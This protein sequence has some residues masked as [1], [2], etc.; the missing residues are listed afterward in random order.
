MSK[1]IRYL[2]PY[3][4]QLIA[5]FVLVYVQV[6][7]DLKLPDFM[8]KIIDQGIVKSDTAIILQNGMQ[9]LLFALVGAACAVGVGYLAS[10]IGAG[11]SKDVRNAVFAK[12]ESFS[13]SEFDK[14][15][16]AFL[17]TCTTNDIQQLQMILIMLL[18]MVIAAPIMGI[19]GIL[20][21]Q[22]SSMSWIIAVAVSVLVA[23]I[24]VLFSFALPQFKKM[25]KLIDRL[26]LV[27][28]EFLTGLRVIRAFNTQKHEESKFDHVNRELTKVQLFVN[29]LMAM[30]MPFMMLAMNLTMVAI[31]WF[32][33]KRIDAGMLQVGDMMAFIQYAMLIMMSFLM[34]TMVFIILPR[35]S[36]S[37][38]RIRQV[39]ETLPT[40]VDPLDPVNLNGIEVGSI[41]FKNVSF[42]YPGAE[43]PVLRNITFA[44][45]PGETTA[46]IG[47]TGC[48][49]TTLINL[50]PR[51]YDVT[52][53]QVL[54]D[55]IDVRTLRQSELR[56]KIGYVPQKGSLFSGTV[57]S[58]IKFGKLDATQEE[59]EHAAQ[60]AQA[61]G[62]ILEKDEKFEAPIAQGG[63]NVSGGQRQRLAIARALIKKPEVYI[64]DDSF[65]ALDYK[66]DVALRKALQGET[67][68]STVLIVAQR[69]GTI[70]NADRIIVLEK[71]EIAG[72]GTHSELMKNCEVYREIA[73]S[74]LSKEE[75]A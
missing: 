53:G 11:F 18:R 72:I 47:S 59:V 9:M 63:T 36:V 44:A 61:I 16:P 37:A 64:F 40:V 51:F 68:A 74:Q 17:I 43:E 4:L 49:K 42:S 41:E 23:V 29:R 25:Q 71:G 69:I 39:L 21:I 13:L 10:R 5:L 31:I 60:T 52:G 73:F 75:L 12:V 22:H 30:L 1:L 45:Q 66:T 34:A 62:F 8:S 32:G 27:T 57:D 38:G 7:T 28:R 56:E 20:K 54:V 26:N 65:S 58:N 14:F 50:I 67:R 46:I 33:A 35:A 19:G 2:K 15:S 70:K 24:V 3:T 48:G 6:M 55:G